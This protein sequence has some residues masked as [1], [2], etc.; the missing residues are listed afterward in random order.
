MI[1]LFWLACASLRPIDGDLPCREAGYAIAWRTLEC[2]GDEALANAR[3]EAFEANYTC[4]EVD[5]GEVDAE[6]I[7]LLDPRD[8]PGN[9]FHCSFAIGELPCELVE[10]YG[11]AL[12]EW[13]TASPSCA[14]VVR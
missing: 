7:Y 11:D 2:T 6:N 10:Q 13:L 14:A 3:Y 8:N 1:A 4:V 5:Y 9:W 12:D